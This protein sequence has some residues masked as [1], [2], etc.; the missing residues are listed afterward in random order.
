M[1]HLILPDELKKAFQLSTHIDD[2][3]LLRM[4]DE[5]EQLHV[6]PRTGDGLYADLLG[7]QS[8]LDKEGYPAEYATLMQGGEYDAATP[9]GGTERRTFRGLAAATAY[10]AYSR[11]VKRMDDNVTRFG[12]MNKSDDYSAR[13]ELK[14]KLA[15]E[16]DALAIGDAYMADCLLYVESHRAAFPLFRKAGKAKNRLNIKIIG[17]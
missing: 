4:I 14:E 1:A 6:K 12:L 3:K 10:Y 7:W 8:S 5:A 17:E 15:A 16:K 13:P 11:V 2:V 9:C